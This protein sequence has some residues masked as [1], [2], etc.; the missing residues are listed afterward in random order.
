MPAKAATGDGPKE[1]VGLMEQPSMGSRK[2]CA[3]M[4][5]IAIGYTP[6]GPPP[7]V[8]QSIVAKTE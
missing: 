3:T 2:R 1:R 5:D 6:S 7:L 4:T 8:G